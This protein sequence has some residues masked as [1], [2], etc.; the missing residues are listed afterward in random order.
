MKG[1]FET[2]KASSS[3]P[4]ISTPASRAFASD[5]HAA[6]DFGSFSL[7]SE[8]GDDIFVAGSLVERLYGTAR[9]VVE[10]QT[11]AGELPDV[12]GEEQEFDAAHRAVREKS[13]ETAGHGFE[14]ASEPLG[15]RGR[16]KEA[17][18]KHTQQSAIHQNR[19]KF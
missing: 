7:V 3:S 17:V 15:H 11:A 6:A 13:I 2:R 19:I 14:D 5:S 18:G 9:F 8:G 1:E 16:T 4:I 10:N 12:V